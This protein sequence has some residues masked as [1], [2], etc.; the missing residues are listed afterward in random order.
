MVVG[1]TVITNEIIVDEQQHDSVETIKGE[2]EVYI[3]PDKIKYEG[4]LFDFEL[5]LSLKQRTNSFQ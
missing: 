3:E 4:I 1:S 5:F 2:E